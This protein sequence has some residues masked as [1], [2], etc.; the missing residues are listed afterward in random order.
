M[1]YL[2]EDFDSLTA[3][4]LGIWQ[5]ENECTFEE[6]PIR[7][8]LQYDSV[9]VDNHSDRASPNVSKTYTELH[10]FPKQEVDSPSFLPLAIPF[11][12]IT[13]AENYEQNV[14]A[15]VEEE[16]YPK[17]PYLPDTS[18]LKNRGLTH[19]S[20]VK[21]SFTGALGVLLL[22]TLDVAIGVTDA[23]QFDDRA[24]AK[25]TFET[26]VEPVNQIPQVCALQSVASDETQVTGGDKKHVEATGP[27]RSFTVCEEASNGETLGILKLLF[28]VYGYHLFDGNSFKNNYPTKERIK[29]SLKGQ[30]KNAKVKGRNKQSRRRKLEE[31]DKDNNNSDYSDTSAGKKMKPFGK[32]KFKAEK[33]NMVFQRKAFLIRYSD[34]DFF[35][36]N[37]IWCVVNHKV[38][39]K[40]VLDR[41]L[42]EGERVYKK[43]NRLA[44]WL[45][46]ESQHYYPVEVIEVGKDY[47]EVTIV[48]PEID[49][50]RMARNAFKTE[51]TGDEKVTLTAYENS[52]EI[53][54]VEFST[55]RGKKSLQKNN[56]QNAFQG[57]N[58][59]VEAK[60][61]VVEEHETYSQM[62]S[63]SVASDAADPWGTTL[64]EEEDDEEEDEEVEE[65]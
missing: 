27:I 31:F 1:N 52:I 50:L 46:N 6:L 53:H 41:C 11:T 20:P 56:L 10:V 18:N 45:C 59:I 15:M 36:S 62:P 54:V 44:G 35:D 26:R 58:D 17:G 5:T 57:S 14:C 63:T 19:R 23:V 65:D 3:L 39:R 7:N 47:D 33:W 61:E 30:Q 64:L 43:T 22:Y 40:Y 21:E 37:Q 16:S 8:G 48:Y 34:V 29:V 9:C 51:E 60:V 13:N 42:T 38:I 24:P 55:N 25:F 49:A 4:P 2:T 32:A 28:C 12:D